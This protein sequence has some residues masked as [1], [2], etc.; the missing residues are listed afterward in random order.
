MDELQAEGGGL[1]L[2]CKALLGVSVLAL[3]A[4]VVLTLAAVY[5]PL[6]Y[7]LYTV[8]VIGLLTAWVVCLRETS[9]VG[10]DERAD[11]DP[12]EDDPSPPSE[13]QED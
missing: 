2:K 13:S 8:G 1:D 6:H 5:Q 7:V 12:R 10:P 11:P 3:V 9:L 4:G